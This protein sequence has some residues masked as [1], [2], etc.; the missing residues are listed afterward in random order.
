MLSSYLMH[1]AFQIYFAMKIFHYFVYFII[2]LVIFF[3][4][5]YCMWPVSSSLSSSFIYYL[6][7]NSLIHL[8][9]YSLV[10]LSGYNVHGWRM[11]MKP[12]GPRDR[13]AEPGQS[14]VRSVKRALTTQHLLVPIFFSLLYTHI[15]FF[16]FFFFFFS[17]FILLLLSSLSFFFSSCHINHFANNLN[18]I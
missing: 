15:S 14:L 12:W 1:R 3:K 9:T 16:F 13:H 11:S 6:C 17:Y 2:L 8:L 18:S 7:I 5:T 4:F 10:T